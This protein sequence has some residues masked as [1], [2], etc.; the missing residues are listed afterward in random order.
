MTKQNQAISDEQFKQSVMD[1]ALQTELAYWD[2]VFAEQIMGIQLEGLQLARGEVASN[3][4]M[5]DQGTAAPIDVLEAETQAATFQQ[6]AIAAQAALTRMENAL[7]T[8]ILPDRS[9]PLWSTALR[10]W[11]RSLPPAAPAVRPM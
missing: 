7:K 1:L 2:L 10:P 6:N 5:V 8:L 4:R 3:Q 11:R 9:S